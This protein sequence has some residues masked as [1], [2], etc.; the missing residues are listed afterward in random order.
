MNRDIS[1]IAVIPAHNEARTLS[2]V[3]KGTLEYV[4]DIIIVDDCSDDKT[5]ELAKDWGV[6]VITHES[7]MGYGQALN[8]GIKYALDKGYDA[9]ITIDGDGQ[10]NPSD[11]GKFLQ[12]AKEPHV[13]IVYGDR[14]EST[15]EMPH[16]RRLSNL[17][18]SFVI[19]K[20]TSTKVRD[21]QCGFRLIKTRIL[22]GIPQFS[23]GFLWSSELA[24]WVASS[25]FVIVHVPI[26]TLYAQEGHSHQRYLSLTLGFM[27]L[28][29]RHITDR[30]VHFGSN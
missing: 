20:F 5:L 13:D 30:T 19:S 7:Q 6:Q 27:S 24:M 8:T 16:I 1:V 26:R 9:V 29:L 22:K 28:L 10:H 11:L 18:S 3:I 25:G 12:K 2:A 14:M 17:I 23:S 15:R 4:T 21:S